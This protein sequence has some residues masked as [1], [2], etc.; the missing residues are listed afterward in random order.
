MEKLKSFHVH[1]QRSFQ[2]HV[3]IL[4]YPTVDRDRKYGSHLWPRGVRDRS[5]A[6]ETLDRAP[7]MTERDGEKKHRVTE[8][9]VAIA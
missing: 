6:S 8:K 2:F 4:R 9:G 3:V 1:N 5:N 7:A